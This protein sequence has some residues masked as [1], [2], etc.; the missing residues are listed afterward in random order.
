MGAEALSRL[1]L[2]EPPEEILFCDGRIVSG[3]IRKA[4]IV[5]EIFFYIIH[6]HQL[7]FSFNIS[8]SFLR[9]LMY[10]LRTLDSLI[11]S[12]DAISL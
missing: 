2:M 4:S 10:W 5:I 8:A 9:P 1:L 3:L 11:P 6:N 7:N 12:I